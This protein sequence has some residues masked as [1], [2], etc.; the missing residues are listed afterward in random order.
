M[1]TSDAI[2]KIMASITNDSSHAN[3]KV[4]GITEVF[5]HN[6]E[7]NA[8]WNDSPLNTHRFYLSEVNDPTLLNQLN[9]NLDNSSQYSLDEPIHTLNDIDLNDPSDVQ[10]NEYLLMLLLL[11]LPMNLKIDF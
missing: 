10:Y 9:V 11:L 8:V 4:Y 2:R 6:L 7:T 5:L 1:S 3:G